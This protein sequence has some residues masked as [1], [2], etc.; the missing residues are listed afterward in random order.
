MQ[1]KSAR[2]QQKSTA[3]KTFSNTKKVPGILFTHISFELYTDDE[4]VY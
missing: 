4:N 2:M 3:R 1:V